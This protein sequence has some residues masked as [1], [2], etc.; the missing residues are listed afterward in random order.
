M[1]NVAYAGTL[2][3]TGSDVAARWDSLYAFL[4]WLSVFFFV[5]VVGAMIYF[6]VVHRHRPGMKTKYVTGNHTLEA[7]WIAIPTLLLMIIFGWG[8]SVYHSMTQSPPDAFE[9]RVVGKQWLWT[10][11]YDD[12]R[13]TTN[14]VF[15]PLNQP[16]K[17][18]M[19]S[20]DV[21]HSFFVPSFR[22]KQDV[23]P[24]MYSSVWF[25]PTV[26]GKHQ[27]FCAEYCGTSHSGMLAKVIVLDDQQWKSWRRN[28]AIGEVPNAEEVAL[29]DSVKTTAA[30]PELR[31]TGF[32]SQVSLAQQG[33]EV[34]ETKGCVACHSVDGSEKIGPSHKGLYQR[35]VELADGRTVVADDNYIRGHIE[36]PRGSLVKGY[37]P[38]MPTFKGLITETEMN[39][40]MAYLKSIK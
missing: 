5:L 30:A 21:L 36:N 31:K 6:A 12:G 22:V 10:F 1:F 35:K 29:S 33:K 34:Y 9:V 4:V 18:I 32:I 16:V 37:N 17:F 23:V 7:L 20:E 24:G 19:S 15:V 27:V 3:L 38:V 28:K 2:P 25:T 13:V 39:A 26:P 11:Q 40:L 14:E 8:Y